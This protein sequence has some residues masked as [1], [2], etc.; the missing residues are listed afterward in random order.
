MND[1]T[2]G[3]VFNG[4]SAKAYY[5]PGTTGW[6]SSFAGVAALEL[7]AIDITANPTNVEVGRFAGRCYQA[8]NWRRVGRTKGRSRQ[9]RPD[10]RAYRLPLK[11]VCLYPLHPCFRA[12]LGAEQGPSPQSQCPNLCPPTAP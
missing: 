7:T 2:L 5:L 3:T 11:D 10:G 4:D 6:G 1:V 9:N 12:R 8:A